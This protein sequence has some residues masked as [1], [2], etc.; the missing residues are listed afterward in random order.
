[1]SISS[2]PENR[3]M[4]HLDDNFIAVPHEVSNIPLVVDGTQYNIYYG[5]LPGIINDI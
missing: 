1:M 2:D 4:M 3:I 5:G